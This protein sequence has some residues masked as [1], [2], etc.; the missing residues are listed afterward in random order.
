MTGFDTPSI[1]FTEN[2]PTGWTEDQF[3]HRRYFLEGRETTDP[4]EIRRIDDM[5][6][7]DPYGRDCKV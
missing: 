3:G 2:Q 5:L 4:D 1:T 6:A 7:D